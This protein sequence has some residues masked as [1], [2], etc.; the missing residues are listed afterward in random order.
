VKTRTI[1]SVP[2]LLLLACAGMQKSDD[3]KSYEGARGG[4]KAEVIQ[5]RFPELFEQAE[6][7]Y[8]K[9]NAARDEKE[10]EAMDHHAKVAMMFWNAA[11]LRSEAQDMDAERGKVEKAT[12]EIETE[13]A[14]AQ[15]RKK[16]AAST[17][18]RTQQM[19]KALEGK[20]ADSQEANAARESIN[21]ALAALKEAEAVDADQHAAQKFAEAEGKLKLA[22]DALAKNKTKDAQTF[23]V[24]AKVAAD[25]AKSEAT[26]KHAST[27]AD[28]AKIAR[29]R[30]LFDAMG[31]VS[32]A[33][34]SM[35]ETGVQIIIVEA[36]PAKGGVNIVPVMEAS[37][38]KIAE[39]AK[40][41]NDFSLVIEGHTDSKGNK[42]K[43]L[44]LS[45]SRAKSVM[46]HLAAQGV[47]P[48]RMTALGKGSQEPVADNKTADGRAKNR[49]I[50]ILFVPSK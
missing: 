10:K 47:A 7:H 40:T 34:R 33:Q 29:Q 4:P 23:A 36:F 15:K 16:L 20:I 45:D 38:N 5:K 22:T 12:R 14:E 31:Q 30:A 19:I 39:V 3:M 27:E 44:Q 21:A 37:F 2:F 50:E 28:Q 46:A 11:T 17:L 1:V 41:F 13:L 48:D 42:S 49:R 6:V 35:T 9:A 32:A 18:E 25:Q 26:P 8:A 24:E 43:N